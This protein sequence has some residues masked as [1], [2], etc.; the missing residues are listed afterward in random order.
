MFK[1]SDKVIIKETS[2]YYRDNDLNNPKNMVGEVYELYGNNKYLV[3]WYNNKTNSYYERDLKLSEEEFILPEKWY[4]EGNDYENYS[5]K[6]D[7]IIRNYLM[8]VNKIPNKEAG[9]GFFKKYYYYLDNKTN[10]YDWVTEEDILK[11]Y[12]KLSIEQFLKYVIKENI[13]EDSH[14]TTDDE[15]I[16]L[17]IEHKT[18]TQNN[19]QSILNKI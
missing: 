3:R 8:K 15:W 12:S 18:K 2:V 16:Q 10:K 17:L 19:E 14:I 9:M 5:N 7:N 6:K 1:L 11:N 13:N 4:V